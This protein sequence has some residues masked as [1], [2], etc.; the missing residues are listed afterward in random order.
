MS[1]CYAETTAFRVFPIQSRCLLN[2]PEWTGLLQPLPD[3]VSVFERVADDGF[4]VE[5]E[6]EAR[7]FRQNQHAVGH[8][9]LR[10]DETPKI[11][12]LVVGEEFHVARVGCSR[13]ELRV[14]VVKPVRADGDAV[15]RRSG[16][17]SPPLGDPAA[18]QRVR[19]Q[20]L[21]SALIEDFLE[22]PAPGADLARGNRHARELRQ[23]RVVVD[24]VGEE[25]L[26]DP[27]R[28]VE[29]ETLHISHR[30]RQIVPGVVRVQ[31]QLD[32]GPD[33]VARGLYAL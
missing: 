25:R 21:R 11:E 22:M 3:R 19:L 1:W 13:Y 14:Q 24:V 12:H 20:D 8:L 28:V 5:S 4:L 10:I 2:S 33:R 15:A 16:G 23:A 27:V 18:Y 17:N 30:G 6:S 29:L 26:L 31:H 32:I 7:R 9:E